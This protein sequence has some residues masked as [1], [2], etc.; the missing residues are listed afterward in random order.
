M[1]LSLPPNDTTLQVWIDDRDYDGAL[2]ASL[3]DNTVVSSIVNKGL[4]GGTFTAAGALRPTYFAAGGLAGGSGARLVFNGANKLT[5]SLAASAFTFMHGTT[6]SAIYTVV[7]NAAATA[8]TLVATSTGGATSTGIGHR[9]NTTFR[10]SYFMSDGTALRVNFNAGNNTTSNGAFDTM[11]STL[12]TGSFNMY[13]NGVSVGSAAPA[14]FSASA[15]ANTLA[16]GATPTTLLPLTGDIVL[17]LIYSTA[18]T[19]PE[20]A[21]VEAWITSH[22]A[23]IGPF[24]VMVQ[25]IDARTLKVWWSEPVVQS[26]AENKANYTIVGANNPVVL[27]ATKQSDGSYLLKTTEMARNASYTLQASNISDLEGN[28]A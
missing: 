23:V 7:K 19:A 21:A 16:I 5:S 6:A 9:I 26:Q 3:V 13:V 11:V 17:V 8:A 20:R 18:H 4:L 25:G 15:P 2:N 24:V 10:A 22:P 1:S 28:P 12:T 27:S 14:L